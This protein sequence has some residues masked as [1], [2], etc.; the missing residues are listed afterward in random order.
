M[1]YFPLLAWKLDVDRGAV[2]VAVNPDSLLGHAGLRRGDIVLQV[3]DQL[4]SDGLSF[5]Q[6]VEQTYH[7]LQRNGGSLTLQVIRLDKKRRTITARVAKVRRPIGDRG[8]KG[9]PA[10]LPPANIW[11][12]DP[13][14]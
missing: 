1:P 11:H 4:I 10:T 13:S 2:V 14:Q 3:N 5:K 8:Q 12:D 9:G 6:V 7:E